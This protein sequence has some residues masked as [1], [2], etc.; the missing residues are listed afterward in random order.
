MT[1]AKVYIIETDHATHYYRSSKLT[2]EF[3]KEYCNKPKMTVH[4]L[5]AYMRGTIKKPPGIVNFS[6]ICLYK[7]LEKPFYELYG[8]TL[9]KNCSKHRQKKNYL[10][11]DTL[12]CSPCTEI[13][14]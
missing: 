10:L 5:D 14:T 1:L 12:Y 3:L 8:D 2:V 9:D 7:F 11:F 6:A 4:S 13:I